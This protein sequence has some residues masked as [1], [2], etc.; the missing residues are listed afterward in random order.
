MGVASGSLAKG[1]TRPHRL[2]VVSLP[3]GHVRHEPPPLAVVHAPREWKG[4][5]REGHSHA[6][7]LGMRQVNAAKAQAKLARLAI[8]VL[9]ADPEKKADSIIKA[10][11]KAARKLSYTKS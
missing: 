5:E 7:V 2:T 8:V 3:V 11:E 4:W 9:P 1:K 10:E 6:H